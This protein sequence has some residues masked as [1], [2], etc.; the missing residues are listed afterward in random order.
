MYL[1]QDLLLCL[2][3][4]VCRSYIC[5]VSPAKMY[6]YSVVGLGVTF[7]VLHVL[8]ISKYVIYQMSNS[9]LYLLPWGSR[10][11]LLSSRA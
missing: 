7:E 8:R 2:L 5:Q 11:Q 6:T 4:V 1:S 9:S 3:L 10:I